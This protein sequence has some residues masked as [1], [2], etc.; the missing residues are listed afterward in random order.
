MGNQKDSPFALNTSQLKTST[1]PHV[2]DLIDFSLGQAAPEIEPQ[3]R[4]HLLAENCSS[5]RNW[6]DQAARHRGR[7]P[8][9]W[10]KV[11]LSALAL[12]ASSPPT[13][14]PTPVP[15]NA[16]WQRQAFRALEKQLTMLEDS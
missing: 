16:K 4:H 3:I 2:A 15:E 7:S 6:V 9:D 1:C 8:I 14:D 5:C 11:T 13:S 10:T 12:P